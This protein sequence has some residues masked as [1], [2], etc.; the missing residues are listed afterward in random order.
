MNFDTIS[1][2]LLLIIVMVS[3]SF[4]QNLA[5]DYESDF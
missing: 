1:E 4:L 3:Y 5:L 2:D